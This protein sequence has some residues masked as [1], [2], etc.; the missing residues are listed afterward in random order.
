M[1]P[2]IPNIAGI[3][4][5]TVPRFDYTNETERQM[6]LL[7]R[8]HEASDLLNCSHY[9]SLQTPFIVVNVPEILSVVEK[10]TVGR[11]LENNCTH[12]RSKST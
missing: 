9:H 4:E 12:A 10:W 3:A 5:G 6:A 8:Q 11:S 2:D 7:Y 1:Q